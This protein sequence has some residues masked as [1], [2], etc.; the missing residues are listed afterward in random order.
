MSMLTYDKKMTPTRVKAKENHG[1]N[2]DRL[3][4]HSAARIQPPQPMYLDLTNLP[5]SKV[6]AAYRLLDIRDAHDAK[7]ISAILKLPP[8]QAN[9]A[10]N[11]LRLSLNA[12]DKTNAKKAE[13]AGP[14]PKTT[15]PP[16]PA[17]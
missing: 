15:L 4:N 6:E 5:G 10:I 11:D 2:I 12:N 3:L 8:E 13:P 7:L 17:K 9:K 14:T 16:E 1:V